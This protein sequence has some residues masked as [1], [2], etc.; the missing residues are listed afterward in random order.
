MNRFDL[1]R[2]EPP[3][4]AVPDLA[5]SASHIRPR[6]TLWLCPL[7]TW[8]RESSVPARLA[9]TQCGRGRGVVS[10]TLPILNMAAG[11]QTSRWARPHP[12]PPRE[13]CSLP[14]PAHTP[15]SGQWA[16]PAFRYASPSCPRV[17]ALAALSNVIGAQSDRFCVPGGGSRNGF[18][19]VPLLLGGD[20]PLRPNSTP[21]T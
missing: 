13:T 8:R 9:R 15:H 2:G 20:N 16:N 4:G 10:W 6:A 3:R 12:T 18:Q 19:I 5:R 17:G 21:C 14:G 7:P 11:E 1:C